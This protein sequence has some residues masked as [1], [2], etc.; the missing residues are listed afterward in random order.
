MKQYSRLIILVGGVLAL[1]SFALPWDDSHSGAVLANS[2]EA[3]LL[4]IGL[5]AALTLLVIGIYKLKRQSK[6]NLTSVIMI[7]LASSLF[8]VMMTLLFL[9]I[10]GVWGSFILI[11]FMTFLGI[12]VVIAFV[13]KLIFSLNSAGILA[14]VLYN[15]GLSSGFVLVLNS[16]DKGFNI[17]IISFIA[18]LTMIGVGIFR[19]IKETQWRSWSTFLVLM[20]SSMG[21]CCFL[22]L[23]LGDSLNFKVG[24][25]YLTNPRYGGF[26]AVIGFI[27]ALIGVFCCME[28]TNVTD[29]QYIHE[30]K[31]KSNGNEE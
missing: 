30:N 4:T 15:I 7:T 2:G 8:I 18:T 5:V 12:I 31:T 3:T 1:F 21:I 20:S 19:Y 17:F 6:L 10:I 24:D 23:F 11:Q 16:I 26:V 27:L 22:V 25:N 13:C 14:I 9:A 29:Y 28:T